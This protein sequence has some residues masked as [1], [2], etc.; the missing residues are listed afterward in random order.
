METAMKE[1]D[2]PVHGR[3]YELTEERDIAFAE[4][5]QEASVNLTILPSGTTTPAERLLIREHYLVR[6]E[7]R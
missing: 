1:V 5:A 6:D 3:C 7:R 2:H 4:I